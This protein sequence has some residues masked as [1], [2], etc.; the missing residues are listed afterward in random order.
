MKDLVIA[1]I[2]TGRIADI[3]H[4]KSFATIPGIRI[5]YACDLIKEKAEEY[6]AKYPRV[7]QVITDYHVALA[8][9][10][11]DAVYVLTPN[12]AHHVIAIDALNAGKH[13][14]CEKPVALTYPL[15]LQMA[16]AAEKN[17]RMLNVGVC[18]RYNLA[19]EQLHDLNAQGRF[20]TIYHVLCSFRSSRMIPGLGGA[21]TDKSKS[22][23]GVIID[24]GVHFFD[25][26]FYILGGA[27]V[28]TATCDT[29]REMAKNMK[30]YR[31]DTMWAED[32]SDVVHGVNDVEDYASG[33][34]R[35][36]KASINFDGCWAE[37][38]PGDYLYIDFMGDKAGAHLRYG[39][40]YDLFD[41]QNLKTESPKFDIPS[42]FIKEDEAF[43]ECIRSGKKSRSN[44]LE[45][46]ETEKLMDGLYE[47]AA[48][49]K[50]I[51][52]K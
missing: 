25:L 13:V 32:T 30:D 18:N 16:A 9:P 45:N 50:E 11:V 35:T 46:L 31:Y 43:F 6:K 40:L 41:G 42:Q 3:G 49:K 33:Y 2:G 44:I 20:G 39:S 7:E 37:N 47:S 51:I 36:D 19:V 27:S 1:I 17:H 28:K 14:F 52:F 22:G 4:G 5:K 34:I 10:E 29:Y 15:A 8:D 48:A 23:G 26:I 21:F 12:Y 38:I 24:W